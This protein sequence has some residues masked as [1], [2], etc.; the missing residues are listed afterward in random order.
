MKKLFFLA[1]CAG[2]LASCSDGDLTVK[3]IDFDEVSVQFCDELQTTSGN[4]L[5]KIDDDEALILE[6]Q[7]G[8]LSQ[9]IVGGTIITESSI[10]NQSRLIYRIF[11]ETVDSNY[12]CDAFPPATPTV[13]EEIEAEDGLVTIETTADEDNANFVHTLR[14]SDVSFVR[15]NGERLTDLTINEF[16]EVTTAVPDEEEEEAL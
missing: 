1:L 13:I 6:L 12:F 9:G 10:P 5:F 2:L 4:I 8:V 16:G 11:S 15:K 7:S 3:S 14:L